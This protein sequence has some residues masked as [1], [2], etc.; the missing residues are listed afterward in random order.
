[1]DPDDPG[2]EPRTLF[3]LEHAI[4]DGRSDRAGSRRV[5]SRQLQFVEI[6]RHGVA[7]LAGPAPY[8][9]Y[10][11]VAEEERALLAPTLDDLRRDGN[12]EGAALSYAIAEL[13]PRH[14]AEVRARKEPLLDKT[15]AAVK[16]RLTKEAIH[17][18]HRAEMLRAQEQAGKQPRMNS[19]RA[20][21]RADELLARLQKR[22]EEIAQERRLAALPPVA[23]GGALVVP[24]GMLTRVRGDAAGDIAT[25]RERARVERLA[26]E[27]VIVAERALGYA[28]RDVSAAKC[29]YD[30]ESAVPGTGRLRFIEV[31]GRAAEADTVTVTRNEILTALN[32]PDDFILAVVRVEGDA[33]G[34]PVYVR[35][36]FGRE[37]DFGVTSVNYKLAELLAR[38]EV[39]V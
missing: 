17:W 31:K 9:D 38:G 10:R 29:G 5:V 11:P 35:R 16:D 21:Q 36:P 39:P 19:E 8:L 4:Q 23:L 7:R 18:E 13:V 14:L 26:M 33:A 34:A 2:E 1:M 12:A 3:Y 30:V 15:W 24:A 25:A 32:K 6:D 27:A 28:P 37:P 22:Q 20:R